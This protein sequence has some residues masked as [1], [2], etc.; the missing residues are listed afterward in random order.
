MTGQLL[1]LLIS[2]GEVALMVGL[3]AA[4]FGRRDTPIAGRDG[5]AER[6]ARD[7]AGFRPG[8]GALGQGGGAALLEDASAGDIYLVVARGDGMVG[9]KLTAKL[10][11]G[12][13]RDG[14]RLDLTLADFTLRRAR[15][16]LDDADMAVRWE[17]RLRG[18]R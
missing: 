11:S 15:L 7:V 12:I 3:C 18:L 17:S 6:I 14:A 1:Q 10:L 13:A 4:L 16:D 8:D 5:A 9:R 2:L